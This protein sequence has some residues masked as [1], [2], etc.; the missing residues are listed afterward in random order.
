[1][2]IIKTPEEIEKMRAA[3]KILAGVHKRLKEIIKPGITTKYIDEVADEI[4]EAAGATAEQKGYK[5]YPFATCTSVND[6]ICHGFPRED[7]VLK[8]GDLITVD[9]VVN[10]DGYLADSAWSY[11]VGEASQEVIDLYNTTKECLYK[12]IEVAV[13]GNRIGDIGRAIEEVAKGA[14]YSVVREFVGHGIGTNI[15]EDPQVLHYRTPVRG[16]RITEGMVF[17]IEPM[18]N[19]GHWKSKLDDNGWTARTIDGSMSCQFEH[20]I[21]IT[22]DGPIIL[23]DQD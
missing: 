21:A 23:T 19:A 6:E 9:M 10:L 17:T 3:G 7:I 22:K 14:G 1:M 2:I 18:I 15:H 13:I 5:G 16:P 4:I 8:E 20:T 12:G 11:I